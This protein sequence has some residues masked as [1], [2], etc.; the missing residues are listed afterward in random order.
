MPHVR[1][2]VDQRPAWPAHAACEDDLSP[3]SADSGIEMEL[4]GERLGKK[5]NAG[6]RSGSGVSGRG[7]RGTFA[8]TCCAHGR[9]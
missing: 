7:G 4:G 6:S 9:I 3:H 2:F 8:S 1:L 5:L